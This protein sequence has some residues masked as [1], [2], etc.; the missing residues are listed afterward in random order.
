MAALRSS[1]SR[2]RSRRPQRQAGAVGEHR[3]EG[4]GGFSK[5]G[6]RV[7]DLTDCEGEEKDPTGLGA[8]T[9]D[10]QGSESGACHNY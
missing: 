6:P 7:S 5:H 8:S 1:G 9:V 2:P 3:R 10:A 4:L